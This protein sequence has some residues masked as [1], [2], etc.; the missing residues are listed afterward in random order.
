MF[1]YSWDIKF[2]FCMYGVLHFHEKSSASISLGNCSVSFEKKYALVTL[3]DII[4]QVSREGARV[5]VC[6]KRPTGDSESHCLEL[7]L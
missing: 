2:I 6:L 7:L 5:S 1:I 4:F 3:L